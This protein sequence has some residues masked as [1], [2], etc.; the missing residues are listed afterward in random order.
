MALDLFALQGWDVTE[1]TMV[2]MRWSAEFSASNVD[3]RKKL[4]ISENPCQDGV[5]DR[6]RR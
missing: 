4:E 1:T 2:R 6:D 3:Q 5:S